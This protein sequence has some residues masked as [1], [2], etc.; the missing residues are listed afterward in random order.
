MMNLQPGVDIQTFKVKC[1]TVAASS[2]RSSTRMTV[3]AMGNAANRSV[4]M[5][6]YLQMIVAILWPGWD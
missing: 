5:L 1:S 3:Q 6:T 4:F 2:A